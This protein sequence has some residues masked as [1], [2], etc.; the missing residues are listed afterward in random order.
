MTQL[1]F[2][3]IKAQIPSNVLAYYQTE[4]K[5]LKVCVENFKLLVKNGSYIEKGE[6]LYSVTLHS[7]SNECKTINIISP[8]SG[9]ISENPFDI[10]FSII[11]NEEID[12]D[13]TFATIYEKEFNLCFNPRLTID[14]ITEC[15]HI[16]WG[17]YDDAGFSVTG[18]NKD[19]CSLVFNLKNNLPCLHLRYEGFHLKIN[20]KVYFV[21]TDGNPIIELIIVKKEHKYKEKMREVDIMLSNDD[22]ISLSE[23]KFYKLLIRFANEDAPISLSD[24][25]CRNYEHLYHRG[26]ANRYSFSI[27][28]SD[29]DEEYR[30]RLRMHPFYK[31]FQL[32]MASYCKALEDADIKFNE[33]KTSDTEDIEYDYCYVYLMHDKRNGYHKIGISKEPKYREKTLQ[34]E[35]PNIEMI[36]SKRFPIRKIAEAFEAALHKAYAENRIR[37]EWFDLTKADVKMLIESLT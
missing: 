18:F 13:I 37:G 16:Y 12:S 32:Y 30:E 2:S 14:K 15:Y 1:N 9:Y 26:K 36:C 22:I 19:K 24:I 3:D 34:S 17:Y 10:S 4:Y 25:Q 33:P 11:E 5:L 8:I 31:A 6:T 23:C 29:K 27:L 20:D 21:D 35:Q 28:N 7:S